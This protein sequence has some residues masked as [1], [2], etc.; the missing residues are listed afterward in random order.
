MITNDHQCVMGL[1]PM[2]AVLLPKQVGDEIIVNGCSMRLSLLL[3]YHVV[4]H[5]EVKMSRF[6][7]Y[8]QD[9][10]PESVPR[11]PV[12]HVGIFSE[13][14]PS[15]TAIEVSND[16]KCVFDTVMPCSGPFFLR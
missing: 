10:C 9:E 16:C 7:A 14:C 5:F 8:L 3:W 11:S 13:G 6:Q 2:R 1:S 12:C 4:V 15:F